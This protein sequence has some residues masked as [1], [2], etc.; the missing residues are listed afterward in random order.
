M[1][2]T[3]EAERNALSKKWTWIMNLPGPTGCAHTWNAL[4]DFGA[5][6]RETIGDLFARETTWRV[7]KGWYGGQKEEPSCA[8]C[9]SASNPVGITPVP[10]V[11]RVIER[12]IFIALLT[13][14]VMVL[15]LNF[16]G[17]VKRERGS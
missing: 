9:L 5:R 2:A 15:G 17:Q 6:V 4:Q 11:Q 16:K 12:G 13:V 14:P 10:R 3:S 7:K 8:Y 1:P